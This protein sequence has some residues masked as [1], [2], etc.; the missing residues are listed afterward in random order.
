MK[1]I[2]DPNLTEKCDSAGAQPVLQ[3]LQTSLLNTPMTHHSFK[4]N[5]MTP[6][7]SHTETQHQKPPLP[8]ASPLPEL[9]TH[10]PV[11]RKNYFKF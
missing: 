3:H 1:G 9:N 2:I 7:L 8:P 4:T 6:G 11:N 5:Y 10:S